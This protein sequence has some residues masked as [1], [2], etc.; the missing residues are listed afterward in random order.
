M[1]LVTEIGKPEVVKFDEI[2]IKFHLEILNLENRHVVCALTHDKIMQIM[3]WGL[4]Y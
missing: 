3:K 2:Y 4:A 1:P